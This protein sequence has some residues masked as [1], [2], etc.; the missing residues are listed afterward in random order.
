M[1]NFKIFNSNVSFDNDLP[2]CADIYFKKTICK[3]NFL[4]H[5]DNEKSSNA[6]NTEQLTAYINKMRNVLD[7]EI[8][9]VSNFVLDILV[10]NQILDKSIK[11]IKESCQKA[12]QMRNQYINNVIREIEKSNQMTEDTFKDIQ[13]ESRRIANNS[14]EGN[15]LHLLSSSVWDLTVADYMNA[16]EEQKVERQR[17]KIYN[18]N[19]NSAYKELQ[20]V[21]KIYA[22]D[23]QKALNTDLYKFGILAIESLFAYC[24]DTL[25]KESKIS[26]S[27]VDNLQEQKANTIITRTISFCFNLFSFF[28]KCAYKNITM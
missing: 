25:I 20:Q 24:I 21:D 23:T 12:I 10:Q 19:V 14:V 15:Y 1:E 17:E 22:Q 8:D 18:K 13:R 4:K 7:N 27:I 5:Y 28:R 26:N 16:K 3:N 11:D 6:N 2:K 9:N